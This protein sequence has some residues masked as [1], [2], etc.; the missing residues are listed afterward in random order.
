MDDEYG[1]S[2]GIEYSCDL[3]FLIYSLLLL[4]L[5]LLPLK[6][7]LQFSPLKEV[8]D[9]ERYWD[10]HLVGSRKLSFDVL[11]TELSLLDRGQQQGCV[12]TRY[13]YVHGVVISWAKHTHE[14][15]QVEHHAHRQVL[16]E[17]SLSFWDYIPDQPGLLDDQEEVQQEGYWQ[18]YEELLGEPPANEPCDHCDENAECA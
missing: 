13:I 15:K 2:L 1:F 11:K 8:G 18:D 3:L 9:H 5:G 10:V 14:E 16:S 12:D 7:P 4:V 6:E 17:V